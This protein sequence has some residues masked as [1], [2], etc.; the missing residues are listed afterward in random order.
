MINHYIILSDA[1]AMSCRIAL[2]YTF[3]GKIDGTQF[4]A[5]VKRIMQSFED[6]MAKIG[7][8][9]CQSR[10]ASWESVVEK[11]PY[12]DDVKVIDSVEEFIRIIKLHEFPRSGVISQYILNMRECDRTDLCT[13]LHLCNAEYMS[14]Y[15]SPLFHDEM[16]LVDGIP[17]FDGMDRA[18]GTGYL[19]IGPDGMVRP[20]AM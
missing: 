11:D 2:H 3:D 13:L 5:D 18:L 10:S 4:R 17:S 7:V 15:G 20:K 8:H 19:N 9:T 1:W 16:T 12:F 6:G 14:K